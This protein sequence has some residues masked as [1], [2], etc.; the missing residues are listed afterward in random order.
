MRHSHEK[1]RR[2]QVPGLNCCSSFAWHW[3]IHSSILSVVSFVFLTG[4]VWNVNWIISP[5]IIS[6][7]SWLY[8]RCP[9]HLSVDVVPCDVI[10]LFPRHR[11]ESEKTWTSVSCIFDNSLSIGIIVSQVLFRKIW[12]GG[13]TADDCPPLSS[14]R[15]LRREDSFCFECLQNHDYGI[16]P[17]KVNHSGNNLISI[18]LRSI[19]SKFYQYIL[20]PSSFGSSSGAQW[21]RSK[22]RIYEKS[23]EHHLSHGVVWFTTKS[24]MK[25]IVLCRLF[26]LFTYPTIDGFSDVFYQDRMIQIHSLKYSVEVNSMRRRDVSKFWA[27][28]FMDH[29]DHYRI[30][31]DKIVEWSEICWECWS[32]HDQ[33]TQRHKYQNLIERNGSFTLMTLKNFFDWLTG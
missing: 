29:L 23:C 21:K 24:T 31:F 12:N 9:L 19:D 15:V 26:P 7:M 17:R 14:Y 25:S 2:E 3:R 8:S 5:S 16:D 20:R 32:A 28:S 13:P 27:P 33:L 1:S 18:I 11:T 22:K 6:T 4:N 10:E 30:V